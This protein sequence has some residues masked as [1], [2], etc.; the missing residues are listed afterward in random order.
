MS[1]TVKNFGDDTVCNDVSELRKA[2]TEKYKDMSVSIISKSPSGLRKPTLV[3]VQS[4][5]KLVGTHCRKPIELDTF[6]F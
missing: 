3:D 1:V 5:G 2:L 6:I 4:N